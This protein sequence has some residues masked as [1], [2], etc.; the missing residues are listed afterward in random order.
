MFVTELFLQETEGK[1]IAIFR[2]GPDLNHPTVMSSK[3]YLWKTGP[4]Q[5]NFEMEVGQERKRIP[6]VLSLDQIR[7]VL[8]KKGFHE[9][10]TPAGKLLNEAN[11]AYHRVA[12]TVSDP[13]AAAVT[14]R[15]EKIQKTIR[16][17]GDEADALKKAVEHYKKKG[18]RVYDAYYIEGYDLASQEI[19]E[20]SSNTRVKELKK[21]LDRYARIE[22]GGNALSGG[23][24]KN[25]TS[26]RK[27]L[28]QLSR[29]KTNEASMTKSVPGKQG[30][31]YNRG[32]EKLVGQ[33]V[34]IVVNDY[35]DNVA[36]GTFK[37]IGETG[38]C[39]IKLN[40]GKLRNWA[41]GDMIA[42][43][44]SEVFAPWDSRLKD[45]SSIHREYDD[46]GEK[47][48]REVDDLTVQNLQAK[49][50]RN[51]RTQGDEVKGELAKDKVRGMWDRVK[52]REALKR[53]IQA[54][55]DP[56]I[57]EAGY[58]SSLE[59][60]HPET[61]ELFASAIVYEYGE[62]PYIE[63]WPTLEDA[64]W[65]GVNTSA[66]HN[67]AYAWNGKRWIRKYSATEPTTNGGPGYNRY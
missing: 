24:R 14:Q 36:Y 8:A 33:Q 55:Q 18:F 35:P 28:A 22:A 37:R 53:K 25:R 13:N 16:V 7:Q 26:N 12:V 19:P 41:S 60:P 49:R 43:Q 17:K 6:V 57:G 45:L 23:E 34:A 65:N 47:I 2:K 52:G 31:I 54:K 51:L 21:E 9:S 59:E 39:H 64:I 32:V 61:D 46:N 62:D 15:N 20:S 1:L 48:V 5:D 4:G 40:G 63:Y 27:E 42:V 38:L 10:I 66:Y 3:I 58:H 50:L 29:K 44:P 30:S 11:T 67:S 56:V